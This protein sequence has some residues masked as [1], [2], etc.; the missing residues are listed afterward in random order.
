LNESYFNITVVGLGLIGGSFAAALK[1]LKPK[2]LWG[3]DIDTNTVEVAEKMGIID[4]GYTEPEIPIKKSHIV[5]IALYPDNTKKFIKDNMLYFKP[6]VIITDTAGIKEDLVKDVNSFIREDMDFIGGHPMAGKESSGIGCSSKDI[7]DGATYIITPIE[8]NKEENIQVIE[9][10]ARKIGCINVVRVSPKQH[11]EIIA[12][13]SQLPHIIAVSLVNSDIVDMDTSSFIG[14]SFK[15]TTRVA[16]INS[17][18]WV[19]L[20]SS[21]RCNIISRIEAF[22]ENIKAIKNAIKDSNRYFIES[23]FE[24]ASLRR[25]ELVQK[26]A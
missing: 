7:F 9:D 13:T 25:R 10:M 22:E 15:D 26:N 24:K 11:D 4:K 17:S 16:D 1:E 6:G 2:N 19:E 8:K 3:V 18:L 20:I 5:I 12:F 23:E 21:N 14:G